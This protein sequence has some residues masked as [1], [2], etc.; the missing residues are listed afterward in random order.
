MSKSILPDPTH[1]AAGPRRPKHWLRHGVVAAATAAIPA[2][3]AWVFLHPPRKLHGKNPRTAFGF[4]FEHI[5][6]RTEDG[7]SLAG[8]YVPP[9][10]QTPLRGV[11][12]LCHGYSGNRAT[13]LPYLDF[14][15]QAGFACVLFDFR[16]HGWSGGTMA[17]FGYREPL[18]LEAVLDWVGT[19]IELR[20]A[21]VA[22]LGESMGAAVALLF[23]A[24]EP[25]VGA[26]VADSPFARFDGAVE[27]RLRFAFGPVV[28]GVVLPET[29]RIGGA[30]LGIPCDEIAPEE[31]VTR[32]GPRPVFLIHGADDPQLTPDNSHRIRDAA[33][34]TVELWE[35][36]GARHCQAVHLIH[37]EY[38][39]RVI[40][41]F[42]KSLPRV[43][44][45]V[46]GDASVQPG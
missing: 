30:L 17:T 44:S 28:G 12:V 33:P 27:E 4:T 22:L 24:G 3:L 42:E 14:L 1:P 23:A 35:V 32:I 6:L 15:H 18:D 29:L 45:R 8:W 26:V 36:A 38:G 20:D 39:K 5:R 25:R 2:G 21:P 7:V 31:A 11:V 41:F 16:A 9:P 19:R 10:R 34:D 37:D 46:A 40:A 43:A 13:M